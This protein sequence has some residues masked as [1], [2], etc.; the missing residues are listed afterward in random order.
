MLNTP[1]IISH[2]PS[3]S[4]SVIVGWTKSIREVSRMAAAFGSSA[5]VFVQPLS[6]KAFSADMFQHEPEKHG[7]ESAEISF[8]ILSR[9]QP[10]LS[11]SGRTKQ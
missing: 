3:M 6:A 2:A 11:F 1:E 8:A 10:G 4:S 7:M 9:V 5:S